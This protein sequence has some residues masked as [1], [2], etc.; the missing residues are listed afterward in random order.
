[1]DV[2]R[3]GAFILMVGV[4]SYF[5]GK[6]ILVPYHFIMFNVVKGG[7]SFYGSHPWHWYFSQG[8][9]A[10]T[11]SMLPLFIGGVMISRFESKLLLPIIWVNVVLSVLSHKEFRFIFPILPLAMI[12]VG[13]CVSVV[14]ASKKSWL[15]FLTW[16]CLLINIPAAI[17]LSLFHQLGRVEVM[18]SIQVTK[19][20]LFYFSRKTCFF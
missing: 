12:Y 17:Y 3:T 2:C 11:G 5:Y 18:N 1:M 16:I 6:F 8:F 14:F 4:D 15:K 19:I 7:G 9:P 13:K 10:I 20:F